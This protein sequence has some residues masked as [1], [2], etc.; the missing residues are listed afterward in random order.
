MYI[1][2]PFTKGLVCFEWS[3]L[4]L[5]AR[6]ETGMPV[7]AWWWWPIGL[8]MRFISIPSTTTFCSMSSV[9]KDQPIILG[10]A[11]TGVAAK[12]PK[13]PCVIWS[14]YMSPTH[15]RTIGENLIRLADQ[16]E[17]WRKPE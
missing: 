10:F 13:Q 11:N 9:K 8:M 2:V 4:T 15:A 16:A 5:L 6:T 3:Q 1:R 7:A 14:T 12:N 17:T